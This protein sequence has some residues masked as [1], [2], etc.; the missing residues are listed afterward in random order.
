MEGEERE[1]SKRGVSAGGDL[2]TFSLFFVRLNLG[3]V[4]VP[5]YLYLYL[6][7]WQSQSQRAAQDGGP[8]LAARIY[9]RESMRCTVGTMSC[10]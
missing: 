9:T 4:P 5:L 1:S 10:M 6:W 7:P 2:C 3:L 8:G